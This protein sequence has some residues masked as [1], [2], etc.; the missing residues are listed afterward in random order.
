MR[1]CLRSLLFFKFSFSNFIENIEIAIANNAVPRLKDE[2]WHLQLSFEIKNCDF[3]STV[4]DA[5]LHPFLKKILYTLRPFLA[6]FLRPKIFKTQK[7]MIR[8]GTVRTFFRTESKNRL[9]L[10]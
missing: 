4:G 10:L 2:C 9:K 7:M 8:Y 5:F 6:R 3:L 1:G